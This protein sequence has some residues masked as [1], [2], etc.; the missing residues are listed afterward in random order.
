[1]TVNREHLIGEAIEVCGGVN[2]FGALAAAD[3]DGRA[4]RPRLRPTRS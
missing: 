4:G 2:V 3:A 1:M